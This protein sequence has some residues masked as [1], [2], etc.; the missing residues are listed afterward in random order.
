[1][2]RRD[3]RLV[4]ATVGEYGHFTSFSPH[5][6]ML[7]KCEIYLSSV[8]GVEHIRHEPVI[9]CLKQRCLSLHW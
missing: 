4:I 7:V 1:M 3:C 8:D 6:L 5:E 2:M 9:F